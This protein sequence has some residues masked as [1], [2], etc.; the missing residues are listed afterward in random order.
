ME[1]EHIIGAPSD[2]IDP[3]IAV[4]TG[5]NLAQAHAA[6]DRRGRGRL[7]LSSA[8]VAWFALTRDDAAPADT[9]VSRF[10]VDLPK[11][12]VI[13]PTFNPNVALSPDGT[14]LAY[15]PLPGPVVIRRLDNV[16]GQPL[17]AST[18]PGFR[19]GPLFSPDG[20]SIAYV[21]GNAPYS[22]KRPF[23]IASL[24]GGPAV[25]LAEYR[26]LP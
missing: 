4:A 9:R 17:E 1:I 24:A 19:S 23:Q 16:D 18:S 12:S 10:T 3:A 6:R 2:E 14:Y 26:H 22:W 15:T 5:A 25:K 20:A 8:G 13:V 21:D 11:D 7:A